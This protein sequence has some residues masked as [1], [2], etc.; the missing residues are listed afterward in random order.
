MSKGVRFT[1]N[2]IQ[3]LVTM[4]LSFVVIVTLIAS[5]DGHLVLEARAHLWPA[6]I[7]IWITFLVSLLLATRYR[8][9]LGSEAELLP[10]LFLTI[11]LANIKILPL[12]QAITGTF[13][14]DGG[15]LTFIYH[16]SL[17]YTSFLFL[18][19][20]LL[21]LRLSPSRIG[22]ITFV[23][24]AGSAL[25]ALLVPSSPN[26][27]S[28]LLEAG[29]SDSLFLSI[30]ITLTVVAALS[31]LV[32][33]LGEHTKRDTRFKTVAFLLLTVGNAFVS[34]SQRTF[35]N[36]IGLIIYGAGA[37]ILVLASRSYHI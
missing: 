10:V 7:H 31:Y 29:V 16:G 35:Y 28:F 12:H 9:N 1:F 18:I 36:I 27:P 22:F 25:L 5:Q 37:T 8:A 34:I 2:L 30:C 15:V 26:D 13:L 3:G 23:G 24:A 4:A 20:S 33:A 21:F 17:L 14:L 11:V 19:G 32:I 6:L